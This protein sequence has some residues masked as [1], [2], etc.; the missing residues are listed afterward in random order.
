[1]KTLGSEIRREQQGDPKEI[2]TIDRDAFG[3]SNEADLV[4]LRRA[5]EYYL[6]Q[7]SLVAVTDKMVVGYAL[8]TSADLV[9]EDTRRVLSF[10]LLAVSPRHQNQGIGSAL[11][12]AGLEIAEEMGE[13]LTIVLGEPEYYSRFGFVTAAAYGIKCPF[14]ASE[15][16]FQVKLF[17]HYQT[18]YIGTVVYPPA[19]DLV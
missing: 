2:A 18:S 15:E 17:P 4:N 3:R 9:G 12:K 19:F 10:A 14:P 7:L 8:F 11:V 13:P 16:A 1:L 6:P 5:S